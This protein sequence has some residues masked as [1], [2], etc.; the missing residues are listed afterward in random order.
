MIVGLG[1]D[2][3]SD[4][5]NSAIQYLSAC[6]NGATITSPCSTGAAV[7]ATSNQS[8][9]MATI[10]FQA[11]SGE[12]N[13]LLNGPAATVGANLTSTSVNT[14]FENMIN[15]L[16]NPPS[17]TTSILPLVLISAGLIVTLVVV[18]K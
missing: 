12:L 7:S 17:P 11:A 15:A 18:K 10:Q 8:S 2:D 3:D 9:D 16:A 5:M 13:S 14:T 4:I 6:P 1:Q